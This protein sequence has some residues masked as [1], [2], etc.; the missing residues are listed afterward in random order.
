MSRALWNGDELPSTT[1]LSD[2]LGR[3]NGFSGAMLQHSGG[4]FAGRAYCIEIIEGDSASIHLAL[5]EIPAQTVA[6]V[7][8]G[9][10]LDR[11]V[12]GEVLTVAAIQ[13]EVCGVVID[14]AA[15]D[16]P[17]IRG[18]DFPL[19][20]LGRTATGP[21]KAGGGNWGG[22]VVCAGASVKTG[23]L[24]VSDEDG[25]VVIPAGQEVQTV[26]S[27]RRIAA[28]EEEVISRIETGERTST[29]LNLKSA[30]S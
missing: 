9:G 15:R 27:A 28:W 26:R 22:E 5:D 2:A 24:I 30:A 11:A 6:V 23:D 7:A 13:R 17:A 14:G 4:P 25:I 20:S 18:R 19:V 16:I 12:W 3:T 29:L 10:Y 21:H 1:A 8:A